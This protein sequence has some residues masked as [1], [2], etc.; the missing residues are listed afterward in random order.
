[1]TLGAF[2]E[3][4]AK[5]IGEENFKKV[6]SAR[7]GLAGAGG[8]GS[9]CALHLVRVG[10]ENLTIVDFDRVEASNLDR[11]FYFL[12]QVGMDKVEALK[13]NLRRIN[14]ALNLNIIKKKIEKD[15]DVK[16]LRYA[17]K[18]RIIFD[19]RRGEDPRKAWERTLDSW[20][21]RYGTSI[22]GTFDHLLPPFTISIGA[23]ARRQGE[24]MAPMLARAE[25]LLN[26]AKTAGKNR[27]AFDGS[28]AQAAPVPAAQAAFPA[29][30][31]EN[32]EL[33]EGQRAIF[34]KISDPSSGYAIVTLKGGEYGG[35][36]YS[37]WSRII[38]QLGRDYEITLG[39]RRA[40]SRNEALRRWGLTGI[41][42]HVKELRAL[43]WIN[44]EQGLALLQAEDGDG[45][46]AWVNDIL[47][48]VARGGH[49]DNE[50]IRNLVFLWNYLQGDGRDGQTLLLKRRKE[51]S[52]REILR[53]YGIK[54]R[55]AL[56][57]LRVD[58]IDAA[59]EQDFVDKLIVGRAE[60]PRASPGT[61]R[62]VVYEELTSGA[63]KKTAMAGRRDGVSNRTILASANAIHSPASGVELN[64]DCSLISEND[65]AI[66]TQHIQGASAAR[67][68]PEVRTSGNVIDEANIDPL[69]EPE[70][71][72]PAYGSNL[73]QKLIDAANTRIDAITGNDLD[74]KL[75][76]YRL[77]ARRD[78]LVNGGLGREGCGE[79]G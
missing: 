4:I 30:N 79:D 35:L 10:F 41:R 58:D 50:L 8:L 38:A 22:K 62:Y 11:Q 44:V 2:R 66:F 36:E 67:A 27:V 75:E 34:D 61:I 53:K 64:R 52:R 13:I 16:F 15:N 1:M 77:K 28:G 25:R 72:H 59:T 43:G 21:N 33:T 24:E 54:T 56:R 3:N 48:S 29:A 17:G 57:A 20:N 5:K 70:V 42:L 78:F 55:D 49:P 65:T 14:P 19:I 60:T 68:P 73:I 40:V 39:E 47:A 37:V 69:Y 9:N 6:R 51:A 12:D 74:S 18:C 31:I 76:R 46:N 63:L 23:T 45:F 26:R 7:V 71:D 32:K